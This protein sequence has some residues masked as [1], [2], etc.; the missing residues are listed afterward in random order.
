M[1]LYQGSA[2]QFIEDVTRNQIAE[3]LQFAFEGYYGH[4][5]SPS[6]FNSWNNSLQF[7]KNVVEH[8]QLLDTMIV[9]EYELPYTNERI[10]CLFFGRGNDDRDNVVVLELKQWSAVETCDVE[11][12]VITFVGGAKRMVPHPSLQVRGYHYLLKDFLAVFEEQP[13]THLSSSVYLHNYP[14]VKDSALFAEYFSDVT[15]EFPVFTRPNF[16]ALGEYLKERLAAGNGLEILNRFSTSSIRPSKRLVDVAK[17]MIQGQKAFSL[18]DEQIAANNTIIDRAKKCSKL[19]QKSVIIVQGGPGT[20]KSVIALNALAELLSKNLMVF[21]ATG[22]KAFTETLRKI[23][24]IRVNKLFKYFNSFTRHHDNE[25]DVLICDEAHR[26]RRTSNSRWTPASY[27][28]DREQIDEI[29]G[30]AKV[31]IFFIDDAQGVRPDEIG[32]SELIRTTAN[33][34]NA[35]I[36][37]FE[38][39]TQ[40]RCSGS[41][42]FLQWIDNTLAIRE[43]ANPF[44][45]KTEKMEF[46]IFDTPHALYEEI[47]VKNSAK[48]NSARLVAGFCWKWS[49]ANP[50]GTLKKDVVIGDFAMTWE[51]KNEATRLAP[52]IPK[53]ALWAYDPNG[54]DQIG[55]IYTIQG[56]EFDYVGVIFGP[57][58]RYNPESKSWEGHPESSADGVVK[59]DKDRFMELVKNTYRVLLSRGMKGCYMYFMDENTR[60]YFESRI[61]SKEPEVVQVP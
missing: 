61:Q 3:K 38:L 19:K 51:A 50:D 1:K 10:D 35:E 12:N 52:G 30:A 6:E 41:D 22:S 53:A 5:V 14:E 13:P 40:F 21:H 43:S 24:G 4:R 48:A 26:I 55:S 60:K 58:L 11:G 25:I 2:G 59:R 42:G 37:D 27:R 8:N 57:D 18:I 39:K 9:L 46:K 49:D 17:E 15:L 36:F 44:L 29:I 56:F 32:S 23:V 20:G 7:V 31:S 54:V 47:K 34:F 16:E 28:S 33:K 45:T